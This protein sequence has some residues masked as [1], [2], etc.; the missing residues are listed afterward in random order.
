MRDFFARQE[1]ARRRTGRLIILFS[2]AVIG[3]ALAVYLVA[4]CTWML[5]LKHLASGISLWNPRLFL[6]TTGGTL[7][8][9]GL[10]SFWKIQELSA[11]GSH[12]A[13]ILGGRP[14]PLDPQDPRE[15]Q[16]RNVVEEMA[17]ASGIPVPNLYLL[18]RER[19]INAFAAGHSLNDAAICVTNGAL[20]L[21]DRDEMQGVVAHEIGHI[22]NG[23]MRLNLSL[24]GWLNGILMVS[25]IGEMG[26][27]GVR[28]TGGRGTAA[29][30]VVSI[31]LYAVGYVGYFFG[32]LIK[33]AV[34]RQREYLGDASAAQFTRHPEGLAGALKKIGGLAMG[35]RIDHP[36]ADEM[37]HLFFGNALPEAWLHALDTHPP[38]IDRIRRLDAR[39][40][41]KFP[42]VTPL[43][44]P[45]PLAMYLTPQPPKAAPQQV[46]ALSGAE[47]IALLSRAG[48]PMQEHLDRARHLINELPVPL[49]S[50]IR[51]PFG[52]CAVVYG[53][54]IDSTP[55]IRARQEEI[56]TEQGNQVLLGEVRKISPVL[57]A[58]LPEV[59]LP[60]LEL[61]LPSLRALSRDQFLVL[62]ETVVQ[63]SAADNRTSL[64][65]FTLRYLL[66]RHLE[67][68][69][70]QRPNRPAQIYGLRGVQQE[71]S[72]ILTSVA[73]V[74]N[75]DE[76]LARQAFERG[77]IVLQEAKI[78]FTFL[79]P[80]ES[81]IACLERSFT[82]LENT[83]S[84]IKRRLLG[85]CL[86]CLRH[87]GK[88]TVAE[89]ELFRAI[90]DAI[91]CPLPPWLDMSQL[92]PI[93]TK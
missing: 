27:R 77:L 22:L 39:F 15:R 44:A 52:A 41:G 28:R 93:G 74:G 6:W 10:G 17:I 5:S 21:L 88:V 90:A 14:V 49:L 55:A 59:R 50:A 79:P 48:D 7:L 72:C 40:N 20:K 37:S 3:V 23:D 60:L 9:V 85:A 70:T 83:S 80:A 67:P 78:E 56:L 35:S 29:I 32:R 51:D 26:L 36:R 24:T 42:E 63:L 92:H 31:A 65:E 76:F 89:I 87:D 57:S 8:F 1:D 4:V 47:V 62:K 69:F 82:V 73:R 16:L 25:Q 64:F 68:C 13:T 38:L 34:S 81:G 19:G 75:Q 71:C 58:L 2:F 91:G 84:L 30:A 86:E 12:V 11:G 18:E 66:M 61:S 46:A 33:S 53:L 54:L 43:P 45:P